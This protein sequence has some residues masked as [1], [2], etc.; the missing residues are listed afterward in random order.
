MN[1]IR[2][3]ADMELE[4]VSGGGEPLFGGINIEI[5]PTFNF[6]TQTNIEALVGGIG[7]GLGSLAAAFGGQQN[8]VHL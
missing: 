2:E 4:A 6:I 1:E 3:L 7:G 5:D 8:K